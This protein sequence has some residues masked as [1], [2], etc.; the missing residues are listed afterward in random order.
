MAKCMGLCLG[1]WMIPLPTGCAVE[2]DS[3]HNSFA[4]LMDMYVLDGHLL[5]ALAAGAAADPGV[6]RRP[7]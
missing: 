3:A 7:G 5:L 2:T 1:F 6:S 4:T